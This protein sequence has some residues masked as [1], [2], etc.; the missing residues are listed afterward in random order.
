MA[1]SIP[2]EPFGSLLDRGY[3]QNRKSNAGCKRIYPLILLK[4]LVLQ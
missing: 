1:E 3:T 2:W 4:I